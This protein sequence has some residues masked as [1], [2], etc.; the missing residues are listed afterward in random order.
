MS[1]KQQTG[2]QPKEAEVNRSETWA[3]LFYTIHLKKEKQQQIMTV[4]YLPW[5]VAIILSL[6]VTVEHQTYSST[7]Q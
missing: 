2:A 4:N 5:N 1:S 6:A 7:T 3:I